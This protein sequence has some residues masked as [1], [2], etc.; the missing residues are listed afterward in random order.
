MNLISGQKVGLSQRCV[1]QKRDC[2]P[3]SG[4]AVFLPELSALGSIVGKR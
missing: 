4:G 2:R 1:R 3:V